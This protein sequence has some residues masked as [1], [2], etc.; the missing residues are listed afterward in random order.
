ML[1]KMFSQMIRRGLSKTRYVFQEV[2]PISMQEDYG[3]YVNV[4]FCPT[5]CNYCPF[6]SEPVHPYLTQLDEYV[7][8]VVSEIQNSRLAGKPH[9]FYMGGGTPNTL[10]THQIE[11]ILIAIRSQVEPESLGIELLPSKVERTFLEDLK[12]LGFSKVSFGVQTFDEKIIHKTGRS[13]RLAAQ[14]SDLVNAAQSLG[15][16]V[17]LDLMVGLE[18]QT[19]EQFYRDVDEIIHLQPDQVSI[20]PL[21]F[22]KGVEYRF[23]PSSNSDKQYQLIESVHQK[24]EQAGFERK[25]AW[26]FSRFSEPVYDTSGSEIGME[27]VGFGAGGYSVHG[28]WKVMNP[29]IQVYLH[30]FR[31]GQ[32]MA[33]VAP[34]EAGN[35]DMRQ[36]SKM[37]YHLYLKEKTSLK[38]VTKWL[39]HLLEWSGYSHHGYLTDKGRLLAHELSRAAMEALP[40]PIQY[41]QSVQ[42]LSDY[43]SFLKEAGIAWSV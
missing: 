1:T 30:C 42:N 26:I 28:K 22:V 4:P 39:I 43:R 37:I 27:Y 29:P 19:P 24:L 3:I 8:A 6:Y 11:K 13:Y 31:T 38:P 18:G 16:R 35:E 17:N 25:T 9:W 5:R 12:R 15:L 34:R 20:Y 41:P 7:E 32:P 10:N 21:I 23:T 40:F 14:M 2:P 33:F 36:I